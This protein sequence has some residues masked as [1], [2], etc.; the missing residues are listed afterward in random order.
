MW[1]LPEHEGAF[2]TLLVVEITR[3]FFLAYIGNSI[4]PSVFGG[5]EAFN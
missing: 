1:L 2:D 5:E 3:V 4:L